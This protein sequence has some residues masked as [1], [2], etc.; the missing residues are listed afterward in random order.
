MKVAAENARCSGCKLCQLTCALTN[1]NENNP[2]KTAIKVYSEHFTEGG[3]RIAVCNQCGECAEVCPT[4]AIYLEDGVYHIDADTCTNCLMCVRACPS[5]VMHVHRQA[6]TP[7]KCVACE[8]CVLICPTRT[9]TMV[10]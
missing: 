6:R 4:G 1:F 2:K 5:G 7:I 3:Y 8:A 10:E 9:L